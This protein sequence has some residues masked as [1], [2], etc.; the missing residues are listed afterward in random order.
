MTAIIC[1]VLLLGVFAWSPLWLGLL[2]Y[3]GYLVATG[4]QRRTDL[5]QGHL[6]KMVRRRRMQADV[7]NL[8]FEA[9]QAFAEDHGGR[10]FAED[11]DAISCTVVISG[12]PYSVTFLR[13]RRIGGTHVLINNYASFDTRSVENL[14]KS[15]DAFNASL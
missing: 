2:G 1:I 3:I 11:R 15:E 9:A 8:Y 4:K 12:R 13:E 6:E 10:I 5:I 7:R 14:R